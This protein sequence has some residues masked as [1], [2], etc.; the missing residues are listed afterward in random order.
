MTTR[1]RK[2]SLR[3]LGWL[4]LALPLLLLACSTVPGTATPAVTIPAG[5]ATRT[6]PSPTPAF[7]VQ[8]CGTEIRTRMWPGEGRDATARDCLWQAYQAGQP[9]QF[10]TTAITVEGDPI[11]FAVTVVGPGWITIIV[12]S[13]DKF[14]VQG[15]FQHRCGLMERQPAQSGVASDPAGFR[16]SNCDDAGQGFVT[17]T[18]YLYIP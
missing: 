15:T 8:Q 11:T 12:N 5:I 2:L 14:G 9:A 6:A 1:T 13:A 7:G 18:G 10:T 16:L 4:L 17:D 3:T